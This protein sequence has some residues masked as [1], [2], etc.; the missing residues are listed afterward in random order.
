MFLVHRKT[1][2]R[3]QINIISVRYERISSSVK[4]RFGFDWGQEKGN[5]L[6]ALTLNKDNTIVGLMALKD[7]P[8]EL[9]HEIS[10]IESSKENVG[11]EKE[12]KH[13]A[14]ILIAFACRLAFKRGYFG[15]VSLTPKTRLINYYMM[16]YGFR[17]FGR[18]LALDSQDSQRLIDQYLANEK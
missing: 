18:Q 1:G 7:V 12:Y 16:T 13:I 3:I 4:N 14:G 9:R 15:F 11:Q 5:E 8:E 2:R 17:Q 6:F 10:L